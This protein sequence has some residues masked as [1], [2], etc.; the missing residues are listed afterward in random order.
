MHWSADVI[1]LLYGLQVYTINQES[2]Y[3][4]VMG[5][6]A[7][8]VREDLIKLFALYGDIEEYVCG[9]L[10]GRGNTNVCYRILGSSCLGQ[11]KPGN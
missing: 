3:L 2:K 8:R 1:C 6:P 4:L 9:S 10:V 11:T 5:V 7:I